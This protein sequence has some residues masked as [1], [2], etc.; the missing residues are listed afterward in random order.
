VPNKISFWY[1]V[2]CFEQ[3]PLTLSHYRSRKPMKNEPNVI[4]ISRS[5]GFRI[6]ATLTSE[7]SIILRALAGGRTDKQVCNDLRMEPTTFLRMMRAMRQKIG[8]AD[9]VTLIEWAKRQIK[10]GDQRIDKPERYGRLA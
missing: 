1:V 5:S 4:S 7:E 6:D 10:G 8:V 9:N 3:T 2:F